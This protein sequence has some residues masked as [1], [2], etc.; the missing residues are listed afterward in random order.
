MTNT[1][2]ALSILAM[3]CALTSACNDESSSVDERSSKVTIL[4]ERLH[5][6][7][8][9]DW[10]SWQALHADNACRTAPELSEPLCSSAA[11]RVA[12]ETLS[13]AFPD[14]HLE[15]LQA[16]EQG[17][18]LVARIHTSGTMTGPLRL[19][20]GVEVPATGK[21]IDQEWTAWVR[22]ENGKIVQFDEYYDQLQLMEQL[23]LAGMLGALYE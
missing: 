7:N 23:G 20:S 16:V 19:S 2:K 13:T 14:Y 15:L 21:T 11:M 5:A 8:R 3:T 6:T 1:I 12:I 22:F 9:R 10:D 18:W 4:Q 17:D